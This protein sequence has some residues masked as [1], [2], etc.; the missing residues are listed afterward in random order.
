MHFSSYSFLFYLELRFVVVES[1]S[2]IVLQ[3][4]IVSTMLLDRSISS[5][6][7]DT[8]ESK[9]AASDSDQYIRSLHGEYLPRSFGAIDQ[10]VHYFI[11]KFIQYLMQLMFSRRRPF[12]GYVLESSREAPMVEEYF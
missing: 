1:C 9:L 2:K 6:K 12:D 5:P 4:R 11:R 10:R 7:S 3:H 8:Y